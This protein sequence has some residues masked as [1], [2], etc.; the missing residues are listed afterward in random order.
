MI[1]ERGAKEKTLGS[2][3]GYWGGYVGVSAGYGG[4]EQQSGEFR[5]V[6]EAA[7]AFVLAF[8]RLPLEPKL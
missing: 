2:K 4:R 7:L 3:G 8:T 6:L 5:G 1:R